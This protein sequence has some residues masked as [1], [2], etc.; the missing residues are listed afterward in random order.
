VISPNIY[1][2]QVNAT[3]VN[4][5]E[6]IHFEVKAE[7]YTSGIESVHLIISANNYS[8]YTVGRMENHMNGSEN[9]FEC[10]VKYLEPGTYSYLAIARDYANNTKVL[11]NEEYLFEVIKNPNHYSQL[12]SIFILKILIFCLFGT[13]FVIQY[14]KIFQ[15]KKY[16][17]Q[18]S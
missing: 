18:Y 12:P 15:N 13:I 5:S 3:R 9:R 8:D 6:T 4:T 10:D 2:L 1:D 16:I 17:N 7:D 14:K 11:S